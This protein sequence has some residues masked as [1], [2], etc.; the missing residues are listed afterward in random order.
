MNTLKYLIFAVM[1]VSFVG[2]APVHAAGDTYDEQAII[3]QTREFF[4]GVTE[5]LAK[6]VRKVFKEQGAPNAYILGEEVSGA[7]GVGLRYGKGELFRKKHA[8]QKIFWQGPSVGFD[9]GG[10]AS[11][12]FVLIYN[13][14]NVE[15][16][17]QRIPGAEGTYYFVAGAAVNYQQTGDLVLAP[18]RTGVGLRGGVNIGY[19]HYGRKHSWLPF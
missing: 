6:V 13:L 2:A 9:L 11:K 19:L 1:A 4:G 18:I 12:V 16:I 8:G 5:G 15:D 10:N 3:K 14:K 7:I 17:Y